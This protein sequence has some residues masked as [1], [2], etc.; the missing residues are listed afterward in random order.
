M[1]FESLLNDIWIN[2]RIKI[3]F[4]E[5]N[6]KVSFGRE[7]LVWCFFIK[8][9]VVN[10]VVSC[11]LRLLFFLLDFMCFWRVLLLICYF[12]D[13][14]FE[15]DVFVMFYVNDKCINVSE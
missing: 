13:L 5:I 10:I 1:C 3:G 7:I 9:Y 6:N 4:I 14:C 2:F 8:F 15:K 12:F 11:I